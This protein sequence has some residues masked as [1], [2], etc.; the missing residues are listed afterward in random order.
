MVDLDSL[1]AD[2]VKQTGLTP[3]VRFSSG[4][5]MNVLRVHGFIVDENGRIDFNGWL[6]ESTGRGCRALDTLDIIRKHISPPAPGPQGRELRTKLIDAVW[7]VQEQ[8][9]DRGNLDVL[10]LDPGKVADAVLFALRSGG[11][12]DST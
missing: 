12:E 5:T 7:S 2:I 10:D 8:A 11:G 4:R 6:N 1:A 9:Y 3:Q